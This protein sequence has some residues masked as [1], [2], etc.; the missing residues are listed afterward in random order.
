MAACMPSHTCGGPSNGDMWV[1]TSH[2][3][4]CVLHAAAI[5][6]HLPSQLSIKVSAVDV[7]MFQQRHVHASISHTACLLRNSMGDL[8]PILPEG[9]RLHTSRAKNCCGMFTQGQRAI[10]SPESDGLQTCPAIRTAGLAPRAGLP[11]TAARKGKWKRKMAQID[12]ASA[13]SRWGPSMRH[14]G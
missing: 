5:M 12:W 11:P 9:F 4:R 8:C 2:Q 10:R 13:P 6:S 3:V 14:V 7:C 1:R